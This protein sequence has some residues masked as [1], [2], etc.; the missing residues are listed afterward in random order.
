[1]AV[2]RN[3]NV[4]FITAAQTIKNVWEGGGKIGRITLSNFD[5]NG[6]TVKVYD[7]DGAST[8]AKQVFEAYLDKIGAEDG[9]VAVYEL[10]IVCTTGVSVVVTGVSVKVSIIMESD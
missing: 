1:M 3:N 9:N 5:A 2:Y 10:G 4:V 8:A 7:T 6:S